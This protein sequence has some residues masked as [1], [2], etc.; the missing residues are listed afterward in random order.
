MQLK[1]ITEDI[2]HKIYT[3]EGAITGLRLVLSTLKARKGF[4]GI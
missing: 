4:T 2:L 1:K 3:E